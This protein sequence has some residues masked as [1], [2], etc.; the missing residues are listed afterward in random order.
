MSRIEH[1]RDL[2]VT[3]RGWKVTHERVPK[4]Q[5]V[6]VKDGQGRIDWDKTGESYPLGPELE[7]KLKRK[8]ESQGWA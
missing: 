5:D 7:R 6:A 4:S 1:E 3:G 8:R 2:P